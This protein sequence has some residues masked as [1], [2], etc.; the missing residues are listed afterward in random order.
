MAVSCERV[1]P[2]PVKIIARFMTKFYVFIQNEYT[3]LFSMEAFPNV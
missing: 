3:A 2:D 1:L